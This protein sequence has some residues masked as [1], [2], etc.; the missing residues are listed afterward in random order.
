VILDRIADLSALAERASS[1][2]RE[3]NEDAAFAD[4][5]ERVTA[6]HSLFQ[7]LGMAN[8]RLLGLLTEDEQAG[9]ERAAASASKALEVL[10]KASDAELAAY[11]STTAEKRG[12][13]RAVS[14]EATGLRASLLAAQQ[15]L[16][17][18]V[19]EEVWPEDDLVRLAVVSHISHNG[20]PAQVDRD[21]F[22]VR[23]KLIEHA[24]DDVGLA[25]DHIDRL[26][27]EATRAAADA[28]PLRQIEVSDEVIEFW[29]AAEQGVGLESLTPSIREWLETH[30]ALTLFTVSRQ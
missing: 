12:S 29:K 6:A 5:G 3:S 18:R 1:T 19:G 30:D 27:S 22:E 8:V 21:V 17:H 7:N 4:V 13:L 28:Q 2:A 26:V 23:K 14:R 15:S 11:S 20:S 10:A 24:N 25:L 9:V 16:L